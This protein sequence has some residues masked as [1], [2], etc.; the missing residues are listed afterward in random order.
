MD[1]KTESVLTKII[2]T[3]VF[4]FVIFMLLRN[5][6]DPWPVLLL[7]GLFI[8]SLTLRKIFVYSSE[9]NKRIGRFLI[10]ADIAL[11]FI[12]GFSDTGGSFGLFY[13]IIIADAIIEFPLL[14]SVSTSVIC[15]MCM[16]A[17]RFF[18]AGMSP[19]SE[20]LSYL[21]VQAVIFLAVS[22]VLIFAKN[23]ITQGNKLKETMIELKV[24]SKQLENTYLKLKKTSEDL[25]D[26]TIMKER[27][28]IAREIHDTVGHTLTTVLLEMEAGER[29]VKLNPDLA[30]EKIG[31]AKDQVRKGLND[32]R[33]SVRM[34]QSGRELLGFVQSLMLLLDE[35]VSHGDIFVRHEITELPELTEAQERT[36][37]RALQEGLT[38]G[39]KH[40]KSS[41]FVFKLKHDNKYVRFFLQDNGKGTDKIT[42]G[43]GL[44]A[45][46]E[47]VT[48]QGGIFNVSSTMGEGC[49]IEFS[50]PLRKESSDESCESIDS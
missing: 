45:M 48:E 23:Q 49:S 2:Y 9:R 32:I 41:A 26:M 1:D 37:Y 12:M 8:A 46:E 31:L 30:I 36:I 40:G 6:T 43:F 13:F 7:S 28:R 16:A 42:K 50:L 11:V 20:Y 21:A 4:V 5:L 25:E 47:R 35:T 29:L 18:S 3:S 19:I 10:P 15:F 14:F 38:N 27:N 17:G 39:I 24:K 34:L 44:T 33:Q 22:S